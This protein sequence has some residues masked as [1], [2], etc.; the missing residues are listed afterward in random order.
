MLGRISA[1][2][3]LGRRTFFRRLR[4]PRRRCRLF[5]LSLQAMLFAV[6]IAV[7]LS[8]VGAHVFA[9]AAQAVDSGAAA[10]E[11]SLETDV[12]IYGTTTSGIGAAWALEQAQSDLG[13]ELDVVHVSPSG[14]LESPLANGLSVE[15][16]YGGEAAV[17][18]FARAIRDEIVRHYERLGIN[19]LVGGRLLYEPSVARRVLGSFYDRNGAG[20]PGFSFL[21]GQVFEA[22]WDS[23]LI[24]TPAGPVRIYARYFIDAGAEG[25]LVRLRGAEYMIGL[26][27]AVYSAADPPERPS[28]RNAQVTAPQYFSALLTLQ[29]HEGSAQPIAE[30][31]IPFYDPDSYG[32][33]AALSERQRDAFATSWSMSWVLPNEKRELNEAWSDYASPEASF[34][35]VMNPRSRAALHIAFVN[36]AVN[37]VRWLQEN[38]YPHVGLSEIPRYPYVREG[39]RAVGRRIYRGEDIQLRVKEE[40]VAY[41]VYARYDRHD[42]LPYITPASFETQFHDGASTAVWVPMG[43][44]Q[45][46]GHPNYLVTTAVSAE[47]EAYNSAVRME[48][49]RANMGG[50]AG[51]MVAVAEHLGVTTH[52]V[53]Y[54]AVRE[55]LLRLGWRFEPAPVPSKF[56]DVPTISDYYEAVRYLTENG[57]VNGYSDG[58]FGVNDPLLRAQLAKMMVVAL[59]IHDEGLPDSE[60]TFPDVTPETGAYPWDYV[61]EAYRAG[62]VLGFEDGTFG[63][64][65]KLTR[66]QLVRIVTRAGSQ[67]L[68]KPPDSYRLTFAD[69]PA[70]DREAVALAAYNSLV[71][72]R[73]ETEFDPYGPATRGHVAKILYKYLKL[74]AGPS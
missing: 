25:D 72:G 64:W 55:E 4:R 18:G 44:L 29:V 50:A 1:T 59:G 19:P 35:W 8:F 61:E 30:Q 2:V 6:V 73:S 11:R 26:D 41:G 7:L 36:H 68:E 23:V 38:G 47:T 33:D 3:R 52:E 71:D 12:V 66:I 24:D 74:L 31:E 34:E 42:N 5:H 58:T 20:K 51:V 69:I 56:K 28:S 37:H 32:P 48:W 16:V 53:P 9:G 43:A 63:P 65:R 60:P 54:E 39:I 13:V 62:M 22:D 17:N 46:L 45:V 27:N 57:I 40:P 21:T 15:D 67:A 70:R 14:G 10:D 49:T